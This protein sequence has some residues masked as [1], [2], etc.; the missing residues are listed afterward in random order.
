VRRRDF[1]TGLGGAVAWSLAARAQQS[2]RVP[3]V[4]VL[5]PGSLATVPQKFLVAFRQ[6]LAEIGYVEGRNVAIEYRWAEGHYDRLRALGDDLVRRKVAVLA[7]VGNINSALA[8]KTATTTIPIVFRTGD[9]PVASGVVA[10]LNRPNGNVTGVTSV[11]TE[12]SPKRLQLVHEMVP[13][14]TSVAVLVN[15]TST[16]KEPWLQEVTEAARA[17]GLR[18]VVLTASDPVEIEAAFATIDRQGL[19]ALIVQN[20]AFFLYDFEQ[21]V[22]LAARHKVVT[23]YHAREAVDAGGLMSYGASIAEEYRLAGAYVG[24]ILKGESPADLP[25]VQPSKFEFVINLRAATQLG[26]TVPPT[27]LALADQ[28]IE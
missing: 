23:I 3:V 25:V 18:I 1:T 8:A 4:G 16:F 5:H 19:G 28:V 20:D 11:S 7:A 10:S 21:L 13:A 12:L 22:A 14:A 27:L 6:G 24:R 26:L 15:P 17:L 2:E 9:D